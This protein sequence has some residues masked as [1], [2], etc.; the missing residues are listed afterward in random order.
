MNYATRVFN[1][2]CFVF[3]YRISFVRPKKYWKLIKLEAKNQIFESQMSYFEYSIRN[4]WFFASNFTSFQYFL[5]RSKVLTSSRLYA[6]NTSNR[7][8]KYSKL[9]KLAKKCHILNHIIQNMTYAGKIHLAQLEKIIL[10]IPTT[11]L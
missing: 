5:G 7:T 9:A 3:F 2:F 11:V 8:E 6:F 4:I 10:R 1:F